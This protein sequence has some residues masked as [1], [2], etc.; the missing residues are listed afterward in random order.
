MSVSMK[1][2]DCKIYDR[3]FAGFLI[4][5]FYVWNFRNILYR[6]CIIIYNYILKKIS[7]NRSDNRSD[8][9]STKSKRGLK[10]YTENKEL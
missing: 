7:D 3:L 5:F 10:S 2:F 1:I 6:A 9:I 8:N 4:I